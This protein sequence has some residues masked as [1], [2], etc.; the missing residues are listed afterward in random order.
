MITFGRAFAFLL[1]DARRGSPGRAQLHTV[2]KSRW[3][4]PPHRIQDW[5]NGPP[6]N[7]TSSPAHGASFLK[8]HTTEDFSPRTLSTNRGLATPPHPINAVR[9]AILSWANFQS[10]SQTS[11]PGKG[12]PT[13]VLYAAALINV[14]VPDD[15]LDL[16]ADYPVEPPNYTTGLPRCEGGSPPESPQTIKRSCGHEMRHGG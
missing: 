2:N 12:V 16:L 6:S 9:I 10:F 1:R 7:F 4:V 11:D 13:T 15:L 3:V 5:N 8:N 14:V